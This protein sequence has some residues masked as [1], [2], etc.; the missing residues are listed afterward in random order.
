M[1]KRLQKVIEQIEIEIEE[2]EEQP[3]DADYNSGLYFAYTNVLSM[4]TREGL[5]DASD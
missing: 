4:L 5:Y 3:N 1:L 2:A